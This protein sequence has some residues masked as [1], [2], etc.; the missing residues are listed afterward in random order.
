MS[1]GKSLSRSASAPSAAWLRSGE[2]AITGGASA[3]TRAC[4]LFRSRATRNLDR[5]LDALRANG[6]ELLDD[7]LR[8]VPKGKRRLFATSGAT[9]TAYAPVPL[10]G[11][12]KHL[13]C[14][15]YTSLSGTS[16]QP[17]S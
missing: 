3:S 1:S 2:N 15:Q 7:G 14:A 9:A 10:T 16:N 8:L 4:P 11:A 13:Y 5:V 6:V 12:L 17:D